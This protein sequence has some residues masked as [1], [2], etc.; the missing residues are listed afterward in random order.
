MTHLGHS[1]VVPGHWVNLLYWA[2]KTGKRYSFVFPGFYFIIRVFELRNQLNFETGKRRGN[3]NR[4]CNLWCA[5][6]FSRV[7]SRQHC[8]CVIDGHSF[9]SFM[10]MPIGIV[11]CY[12]CS[13][14]KKI[15]Y[16]ITVPCLCC[17]GRL[18]IVRVFDY[19]AVLLFMVLR[20]VGFFQRRRLA[21]RVRELGDTQLRYE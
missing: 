4:G 9:S 12:S 16:L 19:T 15:C 13:L 2:L 20:L 6:L 21:R 8:N 17:A 5:S 7:W 18:G 1:L 11:G 10:W 3:Q 14:P